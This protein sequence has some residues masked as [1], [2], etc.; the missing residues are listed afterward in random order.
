MRI[1][2]LPGFPLHEVTIV[3]ICGMQWNKNWG[4]LYRAVYSEEFSM[5][6]S[7][8]DDLEQHYLKLPVCSSGN[9]S[10]FLLNSRKKTNKQSNY[11]NQYTLLF[12]GMVAI[13]ILIKLKW[14]W[15][16]NKCSI[17]W[18]QPLHNFPLVSKGFMHSF[19]VA[20]PIFKWTATVDRKLTH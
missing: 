16:S 6:C 10:I 7:A 11:C 4:T 13:G 9:S 1:V 8:K 5:G 2:P 20:N 14:T 3:V 12:Q 15:W 17:L 19:L 18:N